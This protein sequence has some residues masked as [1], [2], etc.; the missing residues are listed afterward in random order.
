MSCGF[1]RSWI[2]LIASP[3]IVLTLMRLSAVPRPRQLSLDQAQQ[4]IFFAC[5][6]II[7]TF[8][9]K[10][11][12]NFSSKEQISV[13]L[14]VLD[15]LKCLPHCSMI[16]NKKISFCCTVR[17]DFPSLG[18]SQT[19]AC[20]L[21]IGINLRQPLTVRLPKEYDSTSLRNNCQEVSILVPRQSSAVSIYL[22]VQSWISIP[23]KIQKFCFT[24]K[25]SPYF[26]KLVPWRM[27][28][29]CIPQTLEWIFVVEYV[30]DDCE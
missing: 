1:P 2:V 23:L 27:A 14:D 9:K 28:H 26:F 4:I 19:S 5:F 29:I 11:F 30:L 17:K 16:V 24:R 10:G 25:V 7:G 8:L 12:Q 18:P 13:K 21:N 22:L 3:S 20:I 15:F 6:P